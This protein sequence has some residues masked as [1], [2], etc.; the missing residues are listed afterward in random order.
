MTPSDGRWT[1]R[2]TN[3]ASYRAVSTRLKINNSKITHRGIC[4]QGK[5]SPTA[6]YQRLCQL[7]CPK[8]RRLSQREICRREPTSWSLWLVRLLGPRPSCC[9]DVRDC[10]SEKPAEVLGYLYSNSAG[11]VLRWRI[12]E[13]A[14]FSKKIWQI[15]I[16]QIIFQISSH[17]FI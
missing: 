3:I 11:L 12:T 9:M 13:T 16:F 8:S 15:I 17:R 1:D 10:K 7:R 14:S 5:L 2:P 6:L 4:T